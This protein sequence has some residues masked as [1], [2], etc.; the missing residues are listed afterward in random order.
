MKFSEAL[1]E[2]KQ[3]KKISR[4]DWPNNFL[5]ILDNEIKCFAPMVDIYQ[6]NSEIILSNEWMIIGDLTETEYQFSDIIPFLIKGHKAKIKD[7]SDFHI[8]YESSDH[9]LLICSMF[10][11]NYLPIFDDFISNDWRIVE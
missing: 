10:E 3:G 11:T 9:L 1:E 6:Y 5:L 8:Y 7:W 2:L 4:E